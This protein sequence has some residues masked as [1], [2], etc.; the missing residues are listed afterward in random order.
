MLKQ[1]YGAMSV[2][3]MY[4]KA[5][6]AIKQTHHQIINLIRF[7][8]IF[9]NL[10]LLFSYNNQ[11]VLVISFDGFRY[12]YLEIAQTP[13]FDRFIENGV[14]A[15]SLIPV[16]PSLTFPNHYSIAT[17]YYSDN[18]RILANSFFSKRLDK[19]YSMKD[20]ETVQDGSFYGMEPIW[21]TAEKN[22]LKSATYFWIGSEAEINGYR[23]SI[24]KNYDGSVLFESRVDSIVSWFEYPEEKRPK[25]S[26]LYFSEPDHSGH[27]YGPTDNK[28]LFQIE[29]A[30]SLLGYLIDSINNLDIAH[31]INIIL[32]SDHG[33]VEVS[34]EKMI[35]IDDYLNVNYVS[36]GKGPYIE[37]YD[38]QNGNNDSTIQIPHITTYSKQNIPLEYHFKT[39]NSGDYLLLADSGWFLYT[40][41]DLEKQ[42]LKI[43]GMHGYDPFD[44]NMHGIFYA[45]G[46]NFK[47][48]LSISTF[49]SIHIYPIICR[50]LN[51]EPNNDIDGNLDVLQFILK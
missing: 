36:Y 39:Q 34:E 20:S 19:I 28:T 47:K 32:V 12:D 37:I 41:N 8:I 27:L 10:S 50:I 43:K 31:L 45:Y 1:L 51:I 2:K 7:L 24:Y 25:L 15:K 16:F 30:D 22:G 44:M 38:I 42:G 35:N 23:P 26:M 4:W 49:E 33:M 17:G 14:H 6:Q 46:P 9:I 18:H 11:Y 29:L 48:N 3:G 13:N 21:V 40:N 5:Q